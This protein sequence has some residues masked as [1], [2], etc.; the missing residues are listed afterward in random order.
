MSELL[1][2][3]SNKEVNINFTPESTNLYSEKPKNGW[4][5]AFYPSLFK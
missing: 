3:S 2:I 1:G 5:V 4:G